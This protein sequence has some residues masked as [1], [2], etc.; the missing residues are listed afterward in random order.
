[1]SCKR[2]RVVGKR[3]L[4][5]RSPRE[6]LRLDVLV[7][8]EGNGIDGEGL[9]GVGRGAA[10]SNMQEKRDRSGDSFSEYWES[11]EG[12]G[13]ESATEDVTWGF[14]TSPQVYYKYSPSEGESGSSVRPVRG[15]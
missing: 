13:D 10:H 8:T 12:R 4:R 2:Y 1:V 6:G 15:V 11:T 14:Q 3:G 7:S 5:D 9:G